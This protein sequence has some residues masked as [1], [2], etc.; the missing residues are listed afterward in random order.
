MLHQSNVIALPGVSSAELLE[1]SAAA[2][3]IDLA[4]DEVAQPTVQAR[5][6]RRPAR[7]DAHM[8]SLVH[9]LHR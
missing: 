9:R 7:A 2:A 3:E 4:D 5:A 6:F 8:A 1:R